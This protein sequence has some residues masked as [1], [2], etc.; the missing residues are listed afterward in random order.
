MLLGAGRAG[1]A[2]GVNEGGVS[3]LVVW[4][5]IQW[6]GSPARGAKRATRP[7]DPPQCG[8]Q[9]TNYKGRPGGGLPAGVVEA[10]TARR[11]ADGRK[12]TQRLSRVCPDRGGGL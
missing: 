4:R 11:A 9:M 10:A 12:P 1:R 7:H 3:A 5:R 2:W 8:K 6:S